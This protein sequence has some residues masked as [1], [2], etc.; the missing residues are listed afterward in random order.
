M[1]KILIILLIILNCIPIIAYDFEVNGI[2]YNV[3]D[4]EASVT[5]GEKKYTGEFSVPR[6]VTYNEKTYAVKIIGKSAFSGCTELKTVIIFNNITA[7]EDSAF[8]N[9]SGLET[10]KISNSVKTIGADAF[11][12]CEKLAAFK[13]P[14]QINKIENGTFAFCQALDSISIPNSVISIGE[15]AFASCGLTYITIPNSVETI[16]YRTFYGCPLTSV[17]IGNGV[18]SIGK[19][20]FRNCSKLEKVKIKDLA[21]WCKIKFEYKRTGRLEDYT[22]NPLCY[23]GQL[24]LNDDEIVDLRIP[25]GVTTVE[26]ITFFYCNSFS[27]IEIPNSVKTIG[28]MAFLGCDSVSSIYMGNGVESIGREVFSSCS[29]LSS[30]KL[31]DSLKTIGNFAFVKCK[32]LSSIT[33]PKSISDLTSHVF[34]YCIGLSNV[35][36]ENGVS[37]L[38]VGTFDGCTGLKSIDIPNSITTIKRSVFLRCSGITAINIPNNVE[39]I[40]ESAFYNCSA[41]STVV[42]GKNILSIGD[43]AFAGCP[44]SKITSLIEEPFPLINSV[45]NADTYFNA[46]LKVPNGTIDKYREAEGWQNFEYIE[47]GAEN[48]IDPD[49][50]VDPKKCARPIISYING[51]LKYECETEGVTFKSSIKDTDIKDYTE[52][53]VNLNVTYDIS[54]YATKEGYEESE[55]AKATLC[56]ID[57]LP[58]MNGIVEDEDKVTEIKATPVL[59]QSSDGTLNISGAPKGSQISVF[60]TS[61]CQIGFTIANGDITSLDISVKDNIAIVKIDDKTVKVLI[62]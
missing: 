43:K 58:D 5:Y 33:I 1:K 14:T 7:I 13:I 16:G 12:Y 34:Q 36:I 44:L 2:Y 32:S 30:I 10:V 62:K 61:G 59:I 35:I 49:E 38:G 48:P 42:I 8:A 57:Q 23:A 51:Q 31:S 52:D 37:D 11:R 56:W 4:G 18:I 15:G 54:V 21:S 41:L 45:F 55:V 47:E 9:C 50:P 40:E 27:S 39:T 19:E 24:Y 26:P 60:D 29:S 46:L 25:D 3:I 20:A 17:T 28:E 6:S 53:V 22:S